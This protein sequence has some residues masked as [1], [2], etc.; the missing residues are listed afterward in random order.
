MDGKGGVFVISAPSGTGKSTL[1]RRLLSELDRLVFS[2]S[3]TTRRPRKGE[4]DGRDYFFIDDAAFDKMQA[5]NGFVEWV[6][7][8]K[9]RYGTGRAW[10][11]D[12]TDHG[13][14]VLLD[15]E[16]VGAMRV[17]EMFPDATL[18]FLTPPS[19][20]ALADRLRGRRKDTEEQILIRLQHAKHEMEHWDSYDHIILNDDLEAAYIN[21]KSVFVCART[22]RE[23]ME[24]IARAALD[25]FG[26][27][28]N[29]ALF[30]LGKY[31]LSQLKN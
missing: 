15:L 1:I 3:F 13:H 17:K 5:E 21:L 24:H 30:A 26:S 25:T 6:H 31:K 8:Y 9:H 18:I 2:V 22:S 12:Q 7:I 19:A 27:F 29:P 28:P 4:V 10:L 20:K 14:D 23:R 16:T 11:Q